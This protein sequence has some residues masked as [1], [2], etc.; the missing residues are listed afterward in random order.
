MLGTF[1]TVPFDVGSCNCCNNRTR[2]EFNKISVNLK[3]KKQ[4]AS[5]VQ[6]NRGG[7]LN[8]SLI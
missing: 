8:T 2:E 6:K 1:I 7:I 5:F 4:L 3:K